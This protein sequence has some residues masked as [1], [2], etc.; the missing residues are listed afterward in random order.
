METLMTRKLGIVLC[1][2][3]VFYFG[4]GQ[5][6]AQQTDQ[7]GQTNKVAQHIA[8]A[9]GLDNWD[10]IQRLDF[11]FKVELP[12]KA[13][14]VS[15]QWSWWPKQSKVTLHREGKKS[16]TYNRKE[17]GEDPPKDVLQADKNFINDHY[18]LLFP[19]QPVWSNPE[20]SD[21]GKAALPIGEGMAQKVAVR[22]PS[23]GGYTPGDGYNLYINDQNRIEQWQYLPG[24]DADKAKAHTWQKHRRLGPI[25][26]SLD[27]WGPDKNFHLWFSDVKATLQDG[28]PVTPQPMKDQ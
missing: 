2:L 27:H 18:W 15:R 21:E 17:M 1:M 16:V 6:D 25:V 3:G 9:Y 19:F 10:Q 14:A 11:T 23:E 8:Q 28:K 13:Q 7:A 26:V 22:Y 4:F 20:V 24:G 12:N 5:A